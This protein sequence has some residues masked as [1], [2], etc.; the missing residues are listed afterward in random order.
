MAIPAPAQAGAAEAMPPGKPDNARKPWS[1]ARK[2]AMLN[3]GAAGAITLA[4]LIN[5]DYGSHN[6]QVK[7]EGWFDHDTEYGGADKLGHAWSFYALGSVYTNLFEYWGYEREKAARYA[8]LSSWGQGLL[9]EVGDGFSESQGFSYEDAVADTIGVAFGYLRAIHPRIRESVDFRLEWI[10]SPGLRDG[11]GDA[12]TD[13][14]GQKY[15]L[16]FKLGGIFKSESRLLR[17]LEIQTG[18]YT[19]GYL[20]GDSEYFGNKERIGYIGLGLNVTYLLERTVKHRV[21]GVFDYLQVP[22]TYAPAIHSFH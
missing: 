20:T 5:W 4:G 7:N 22:Y 19:R 9:T 18:Y 15:L 2:V 1:P 3:V 8:A 17:A 16:A 6:F 12:F 14:S 13:Y 10:P 21:Y 11:R